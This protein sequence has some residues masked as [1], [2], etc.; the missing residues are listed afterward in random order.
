M[1]RTFIAVTGLLAVG[2]LLSGVPA[3]AQ[4]PTQ[5]P[6]NP[7][8]QNN[9]APAT[10]NTE[11]PPQGGLITNQTVGTPTGAAAATATA[12]NGQAAQTNRNNAQNSRGASGTNNTN[13]RNAANGSL[14]AP[15][16][17]ANPVLER[18]AEMLRE[19]RM[20]MADAPSGAR[21]S[22]QSSVNAFTQLFRAYGVSAD[23]TMSGRGVN[24]TASQAAD[25]V[26]TLRS[27]A[28]NNRSGKMNQAA[29]FY[30]TGAKEFF[31]AQLREALY[32]ATPTVTVR[33]DGRPS[34]RRNSR[35]NA[36]AMNARTGNASS[37]VQGGET[38]IVDPNAAPIDPNANPNVVVP[39][40][41]VPEV[42]T[43]PVTNLTP[44]I[45]TFSVPRPVP[46]NP[47]SGFSN[48]GFPLVN[49]YFP[50][51]TYPG[52]FIYRS[53]GFYP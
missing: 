44:N 50:G 40:T 18:A 30:A 13:G 17:N 47:Q 51:F 45:G 49:Q 6:N 3:S 22:Y 28:K 21:Q 35:A 32:N 14:S 46:G 33:G 8:N 10:P 19:A 15:L 1:N 23:G 31:T 20:R 9:T 38:G 24:V 2:T 11:N 5:T 12:T 4:Q 39:P 7:N 42:V 37:A 25:D 41:G 53:F 43:P 48:L 27:V 34:T 36:P 26:R 16:G 52:T 29:S